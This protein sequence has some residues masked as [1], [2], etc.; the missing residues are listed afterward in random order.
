MANFSYL[1]R[2][3]FFQILYISQDGVRSAFIM[4]K[5]KG[6]VVF[7]FIKTFYMNIYCV[8]IGKHHLE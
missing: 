3:V 2:Y 1:A 8:K 7:V 5:V 4:Q 6:H